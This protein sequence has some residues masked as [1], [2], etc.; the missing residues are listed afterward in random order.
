[1]KVSVRSAYQ[2]L[3]Q[4]KIAKGIYQSADA[5]VEEA[6][7][8]LADRDRQLDRDEEALARLLRSAVAQSKRGESKPFDLSE[9]KAEAR[10]QRSTRARNR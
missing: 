10:K 6:L 3:I 4:E 5:V 7:E 8:L 2:K 9:M 1:M